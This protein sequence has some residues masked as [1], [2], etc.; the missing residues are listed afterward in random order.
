LVGVLAVV[1]TVGL[2]VLGLV[3]SRRIVRQER[4]ETAGEVAGQ[5]FQSLAGVLY[6]ILVAFVVVVVWEQFD[7]AQN[8]TE[9]EAAAISDLLRDS[10]GL[11][12]AA[13]PAIQQ[14]L[15]AYTND[16]VN[17]EFP[18]MRHGEPIEQQSDHLTRIWQS[19]LQVQPVTQSEISFYRESITRL[20]NL[21][22]ARKTRISSSQSEIP[23][24]M[25]VLLLGGGAVML[26][27]TYMFATPDV[28]LHSVVIAL[29]GALLA[30]V[31]YLIFAMEHPFVGSIA[32][33]PDPYVHV[34]N[35]WSHLVP[36]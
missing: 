12:A 34:L 7:Q 21:G 13:R 31:L 17:D 26:I 18:R 3:L 11:P 15:L 25:W 19:F 32:V 22:S 29:A 23:G 9:S 33:S 10:E 27:F 16:V 8:D 24:E 4:L 6:A 5:V 36:K 28:V 35:T 14:S 20:N 30:F 2:A 1:I